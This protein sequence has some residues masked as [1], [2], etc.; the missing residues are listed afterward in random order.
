MKS[1]YQANVKC[2]SVKNIM[3]LMSQ[4][5]ALCQ[6]ESLYDANL[7]LTSL[8]YTSFRISVPHR[9]EIMVS[10]ATTPF[11]EQIW[12]VYGYDQWGTEQ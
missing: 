2:T 7:S 8:F 3:K 1:W 12:N 11:I 6:S 10:L 4:A 5:V 9:R